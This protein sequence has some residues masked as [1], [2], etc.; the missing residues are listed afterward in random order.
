MQMLFNPPKLHLLVLRNSFSQSLR[1]SRQFV[2]KK[3]KHQSTPFNL[4]VV[5]SHTRS[6]AIGIEVR[7]YDRGGGV[8]LY[9]PRP[10]YSGK[11]DGAPVVLFRE[12][13][14]PPRPEYSGEFDWAVAVLLRE[15]L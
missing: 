5:H 8:P 6:G 7:S 4:V 11:F 15:A 14:Y 12:A 2:S 3:K 9:P 10:E 13:L 1:T